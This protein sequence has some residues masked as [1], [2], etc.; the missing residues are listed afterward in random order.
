MN[1]KVIQLL[2]WGLVVIGVLVFAYL[3]Y[4][5][6][7]GGY[8]IANSSDSLLKPVNATDFAVTGQFGDFIGGVVGTL[9][10]L[11]GTL[12][13]FL[14]FQEQ[15]K[16][17]EEQ[18]QQNREQ[19]EQNKQQAI[20]NRRQ[21]FES[22]FFEML[23]L[24]R[25]NVGEL[26]YT[27]YEPAGITTALNRKVF[28]VIFKDFTDCYR[29]ITK[30]SDSINPADYLSGPHQKSLEDI[31]K[32]NNLKTNPIQLSIIDLAYQ[33][34][35]FGLS[36]EGETVLRDRLKR[37]Y[38]TEYLFRVLLFL[39][40]KPKR[41]NSVVFSEWKSMRGLPISDFTKLINHIY[42]LH[43]NKKQSNIPD[44]AIT[45]FE[46]LKTS[47]KYYGGHQHRL[48]HYFRH[49]FHT[50]TFINQYPE[51]SDDRKYFYAKTLRAQLS[52]YEQALLFA[53]SVSSLGWDWEY[54]DV[55][56]NRPCSKSNQII[57]K[58]NLVKNLPGKH[59]Y[60][61]TYNYFFPAVKYESEE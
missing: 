45:L 7:L 33:V 41:E 59:I 19:S 17:N 9:F 14:S 44:E 24:H 60:G 55:S 25:D 28:R 22:S 32:Q 37:K 49:L 23:R 2:A 42:D 27:Y 51:L 48:G 16:Q 31:I 5:S 40:L 6:K 1:N 18:A 20:Q 54:R 46:S 53:N 43:R 15:V 57:T 50:Y 10:T 39:K 61:I 58:F 29:E 12:L 11:S 36:N 56:N 26:S 4:A 47:Y 8:H 21:I 52:T 35:Y 13:I 3:I 38:N 34:I 30:F